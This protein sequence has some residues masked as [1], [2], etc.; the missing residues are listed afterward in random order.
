[1]D[2]NSL[3]SFKSF[4]KKSAQHS[5]VSEIVLKIGLIKRCKPGKNDEII[6]CPVIRT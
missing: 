6:H 1:M 5:V 4:E 2:Q 3:S